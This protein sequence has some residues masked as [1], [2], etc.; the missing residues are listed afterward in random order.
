MKVLPPL[1]ATAAVAMLTFAGPAQ[2]ANEKD[3]AF[4]PCL[5]CHTLKEGKKK[6][7]PSLFKIVGK[8]AGT[9]KK[10]K[11]SKLMKAAS[12]AGLVWD[13]AQIEVYAQD[14]TKFLTEFVKN[15]GGTPKGKSKMVK[16]FKA[17]KAKAA[18]EFLAAQ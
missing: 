16:K 9:M 1:A 6:I 10:F 17:D 12:E 4:K 3:P 14:P 5:Q 7:G 15:A 8:P 11:Y 13:A 2:A 18:A